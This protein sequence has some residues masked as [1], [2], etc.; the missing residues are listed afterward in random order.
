MIDPSNVPQVAADET[1]ARYIMQRSHVRRGDHSVKPDAFI[2]HLY[3][4]L[5]VTRHLMASEGELWGV[6]ERVAEA[7]AKTLYGRAD[8]SA[9]DCMSLRLNVQAAALDNNPNHANVRGWPAEKPLQKI[10]AQQLAATVVFV[11]APPP[12]NDHPAITS[13]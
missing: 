2:P 12:E 13:P 7:R 5:S 10:I 11:E 9:S 4:D 8:F 6:G 1:F 3:T